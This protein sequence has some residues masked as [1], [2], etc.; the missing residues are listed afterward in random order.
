M[1]FFARF[2]RHRAAADSHR[3]QSVRTRATS[4][5]TQFQTIFAAAPLGIALVDA[6]GRL[7]HA[8][9][10][11]EQ[12]LGYTSEEILRI[13][14]ADMTHPEDYAKD[15]ALFKKLKDGVVDKIQF[16]KRYVR[17]DGAVVWGRLV[18]SLVLGPG[19][20]SLYGLGMVEDITEQRKTQAQLDDSRRA[21]ERANQRLALYIESAPLACIV[22]GEDKLAREWNPATERMFGYTAAEAIG[23]DVYEMTSTPEGTVVVDDV[24]RQ[25]LAGREFKEGILVEN[26]RKDGTRMHCEW[27]F[28]VVKGRDGDSDSVIAFG[29][30]V[31][32]RVRGEQERRTLES[33][34]RQAQKLQSIGTL[35]GGIA[36]DFNNILLAISGN[37]RL[38]MQELPAHD[39]TQISLAEISKAS[40]RAS[41]IVNQI[42]LFSRR[43]EGSQQMPLNLQAII[44][45]SL[46]LLRATLPDKITIRTELDATT[47]L[48]LG[49]AS[50]LHQVLLNLATNG[51][52]AMG[53][54]GGT[55]LI[56]LARLEVDAELARQV[57]EL[58]P[59][60]HAC[61][62]VQ[63]TGAGMSPQVAERIFEPFFTTKPRGQG[64][65]LGLSV[66]HGI[67]RA[68]GAA[69]TLQ[70][71]P[72]AG[73]TFK[74]YLPAIPPIL[75]N[76][77]PASGTPQRGAGQRII[78]VDDEE[79]LVY[80]LKRILE[81]LGYV[82]WGFVDGQSALA[83]F[84]A[85]PGDFDALV[86]DLSMPGLSG[87]DLA[88]EVL[89]IRPALPVVMTSGFVR[90][91][92]RDLALR[93]GVKELVLKP[94][95]AQALGEV[96]HRVLNG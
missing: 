83:A 90:A 70:T 25:V 65:G 21:L 12:F 40:T 46:S 74:V 66:V 51:A 36:H 77:E 27:H 44:G 34:L 71:E 89:K 76:V 8:N 3:T 75:P 85:A 60:I 48:V 22:W 42:L 79:P 68:H 92:D 20:D 84:S 1:G 5:E 64:T 33:N 6:N 80:L 4:L 95:T 39:P 69:I 91:A 45:D 23:R 93:I 43:E 18:C 9:R 73:S 19:S 10:A 47:P 14:V 52:Y 58:R 28:T 86:T 57:T 50:Q 30:D 35:A 7:V 29:I 41:A 61:I 32:S 82:V 15:A 38:A 72:G 53:K 26:R 49:D 56:Q 17:K 16:E 24:R 54:E 96:L 94:D 67:M 88:R 59:G 87:H 11:M 62:T 13:T 37:A 81:K 78:Y 55:L 31:T 2:W 63:D